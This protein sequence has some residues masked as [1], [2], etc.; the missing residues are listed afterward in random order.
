MQM[1][2]LSPKDASTRLNVTPSGLKYLELRGQVH[3]TKDSAGRRSYDPREIAQLAKQRGK[4][5]KN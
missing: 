2:L 3:P 4:G 5:E 1:T